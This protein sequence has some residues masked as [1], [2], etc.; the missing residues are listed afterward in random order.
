MTWGRMQDEKRSS[1]NSSYARVCVCICQRKE[2]KEHSE[3]LGSLEHTLWDSWDEMFTWRLS[4]MMRRDW[5][6]RRTAPEKRSYVAASYSLISISFNLKHTGLPLYTPAYSQI[7]QTFQT[8]WDFLCCRYNLYWSVETYNL[9]FMLEK[10]MPQWYQR[11]DVP[12]FSFLVS[13]Y[14]FPASKLT[15]FP[16]R[17][18]V[19]SFV[20]FP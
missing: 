6:W 19:L 20:L 15:P 2:R 7:T 12:L 14:S 8:I 1:C 10:V 18:A 4:R 5:T 13:G 3:T 11:A 17:G 9:K 16:G